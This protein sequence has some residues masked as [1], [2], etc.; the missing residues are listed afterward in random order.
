MVWTKL[1]QYKVQINLDFILIQ[2]G[3]NQISFRVDL[4][5]PSPDY[6]CQSSCQSDF[7][8]G[9][10]MPKE[11][12]HPL[13]YPLLMKIKLVW[14]LNSNLLW[15]QFWNS[16]FIRMR[17]YSQPN[18]F[19]CHLLKGLSFGHAIRFYREKKRVGACAR[20]WVTLSGMEKS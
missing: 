14:V 13:P 16:I 20:V 9:F 18:L 6:P 2:F 3:S 17:N 11:C 19:G 1:D 15:I 5:V 10:W 7:G 12:C 8:M 4:L